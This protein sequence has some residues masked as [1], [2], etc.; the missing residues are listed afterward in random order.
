MIFHCYVSL[1]EGTNHNVIECW[2]ISLQFKK[3]RHY[4]PSH[5]SPLITQNHD[6]LN[7]TNTQKNSAANQAHQE[8]NKT[9]ISSSRG[10]G[11]FSTTSP[12]AIRD[13]FDIFCVYHH[14]KIFPP[15]TKP[16]KKTSRH[17]A[18]P[19]THP[20][21]NPAPYSPPKKHHPQE[22]PTLKPNPNK[23]TSSQNPSKKNLPGTY[24]GTF[25]G[26]FS[27]RSGTFKFGSVRSE[28]VVVV[29]L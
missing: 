24:N 11:M 10:L 16:K 2:T 27:S 5:N 17:P 29:V 13:F 4:W 9:F 12:A 8:P 21:R 20:R 14:P 19:P 1:P 22:F 28:V 26:N 15:Q 25:F 3:K 18:P 6:H 7:T 23:N